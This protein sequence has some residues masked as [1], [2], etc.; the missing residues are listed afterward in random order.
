MLFISKRRSNFAAKI[1]LVC[2]IAKIKFC[3]NIFLI[4]V[5]K[6]YL[7]FCREIDNHFMIKYYVL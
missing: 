1:H 6:F 4:L 5:K 7:Y 2:V 3:L